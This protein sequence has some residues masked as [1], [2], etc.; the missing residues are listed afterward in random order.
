MC[1]RDEPFQIKKIAQLVEQSLIEYLRQEGYT[2]ATNLAD[3][4]E[5]LAIW[6]GQFN[7]DLGAEMG[8]SA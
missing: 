1:N 7:G 3:V 4:V 6:T 8:N 5:A 2:G